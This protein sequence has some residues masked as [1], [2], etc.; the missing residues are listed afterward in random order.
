VEASVPRVSR[1]RALSM[2]RAWSMREPGRVERPRLLP[3]V[4]VR[5]GEALF[6]DVCPS[7]GVPRA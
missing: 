6:R 5:D 3:L 2:R 7:W 1:R 4:R